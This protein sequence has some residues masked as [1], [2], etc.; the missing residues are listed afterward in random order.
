[1]SHQDLVL[2]IRE[3]TQQGVTAEVLRQKLMEAGWRE[4]DIANAL[5]DVAAGLR[6]VSEGASIHEDLAQVRGVVAHLATRMKALEVHLAS[7]SLALPVGTELPKPPPA[8]PMLP[9]GRSTHWRSILLR[10]LLTLTIVTLCG[11][12][13]F[14]IRSS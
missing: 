1:M 12:A 4:L 3:Q 11:V 2:Y 7:A 13:V 8:P 5:H 6:P 14:I 9:T 10:V